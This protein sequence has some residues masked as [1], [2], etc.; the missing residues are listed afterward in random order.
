MKVQGFSLVEMAMVIV[1]L[2]IILAVIAQPVANQIETRRVVDTQ[3]KL[4][5]VKEAIYGFTLVNGRL[6]RPAVSATDG[7]EIAT[8]ATETGCTGFIPW[9]ALGVDKADAWGTTI[10]YSAT[11]AMANG[12]FMLSTTGTKDV[13]TRNGAAAAALATNVAAVVWSHGKRNFGTD[14]QSNATRPNIATGN[15]DEIHNN[16]LPAITFSPTIPLVTGAGGTAVFSRLPADNAAPAGGEF[17]DLVSWIPTSILMGK[18]V[19]AG[20]LP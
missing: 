17:D 18:M 11:P 4:E 8:C 20:K 13:V 3:K 15:T 2:T 5:D 14:A 9:S 12:S 16:T 7:S 10:R 19:Q 1:V 6:P